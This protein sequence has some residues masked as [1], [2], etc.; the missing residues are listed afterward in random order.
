MDK[1]DKKEL[2]E[3]INEHSRDRIF[4]EGL[5]KRYNKFRKY[6][7]IPITVILAVLAVLISAKVEWSSLVA[8]ILSLL[9]N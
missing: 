5:A 9:L 6:T 3:L 2:Q 1:Q 4:K 7:V 8:K